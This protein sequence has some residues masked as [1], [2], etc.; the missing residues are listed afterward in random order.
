MNGLFGTDGVRGVA[1]TELTPELTFRLG[2]AAA[3]VLGEGDAPIVVGRDTRV[4]GSMLEAAIVAG[5]ASAGR[6]AL[7]LGIVPTPA[8]ACIA[9]EIGAPGAVISASHN[10]V[11]DNGIKFFGA[12]GFKLSDRREADIAAAVDDPALPRPTGVAVGTVRAAHNLGR[13]YYEELYQEAVDLSPLHVIVDAGYGAAFTI[14]PYALRKLG[15]A[16]SEM[17]CENDGARIN[18][19]CGA[20]DLRLL[21]SAVLESVANGRRN[22]IGVAFDGDADRALF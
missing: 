16:V 18:V 17:H 8:V 2:R 4:S 21:Q 3:A 5:I 22:T 11:P 15:A 9:R 14:A 7:L 13:H 19:E 20:T 12:D 10:P 1:N 6:K